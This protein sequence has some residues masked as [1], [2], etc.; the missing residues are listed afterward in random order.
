MR[1]DE[2]TAVPDA[3]LP[4]AA[5]RDHLRLGSGF[6]ADGL[7]DALLAGHLR[8]AIAVIEGR[9][10]KVLIGRRFRLVLEG[11]RGGEAQ[12]LPVAPVSALVEVA[13]VDAAGLRTV[14]AAGMFRL[15]SDAH[16]PKLA[17]RS[18]GLPLVPVSG[19]VEVV[20][21]AGFGA[22]AAV[23]ADLVQAVM[24]LAAEFYEARIDDGTR[25]PGLPVMVQSLIE[26]WRIVRVLGGGEA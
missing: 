5:F 25:G 16:R 23:P 1:L 11:W 17:A 14:L 9:I 22:W 13:L 15:V 6:G 3:A 24:L 18:G 21:D 8:A 7:Q 12:A 10:G 19:S 2:M 26:R 20:F 4:V